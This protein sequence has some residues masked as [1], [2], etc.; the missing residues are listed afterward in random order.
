[1]AGVRSRSAALELSTFDVFKDKS[2][3]EIK[4]ILSGFQFQDGELSDSSKVWIELLCNSAKAQTPKKISFPTFTWKRND[5]PDK[6]Y[7]RET[8]GKCFLFSRD[9]YFMNR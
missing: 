3:S 6:L 5:L 1:M 2:I 8:N 4:Q 9:G 7:L